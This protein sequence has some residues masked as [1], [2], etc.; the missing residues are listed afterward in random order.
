[1][2]NIN[3]SF[4]LLNK[5]SNK[6]IEVFTK[7]FI[8]NNFVD[9]VKNET[10]DV[11]NPSTEEKICK[12][13]LAGE[14]D[15]DQAVKF[16]EKAFL[17]AWS[18]MP[19]ADKARLFFALA[20]L[21][22]KSIED[23]AYLETLD[24]GKAYQDS[25][26]DIKEVVR[27]IR[28]NGGWVDKIEGIT[29]SPFDNLTIHSR[30]VPYGVV[31]LISPWNYPLLMCAWKMFPALAAGNTI[32]LKPSEET[33]LT[34]L[35]L[36]KLIKEAGFPEGVINIL[37]GFGHIAGQRISNHEKIHKLSFTGSTNTGRNILRSASES[38][39][40]A[41]HLELGGKS[42]II[43]CNDADLENA[44]F[45]S[46]DGAF[47]NT[48]QNCVCSSRFLVQEEIYSDFVTKF[49]EKAKGIKVGDGFNIENFMGPVINKRQFDSI[50]NFIKHGKEV[51]NLNLAFGGNRLYKKGYFIEPTV[52]VDVD[53]DSKLA[54]EEIFGPVV[55]ILKPFK[56][57]KEAIERANN[58][59]YGLAAGIFSESMSKTEYFVRNIQAGSIWVNTYNIN[60]YNIPFGGLKQSGYGRDNGLE[61]I[62]E[63]T[64]IK[65][66]YYNNR[67]DKIK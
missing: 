51:E 43:V 2:E 36:G 24:N 64:S 29:Y 54:K 20:D 7:L 59:R 49:V 17:G 23:F 12:I 8:N 30:R 60:P 3:E 67:L 35:K 28:Y 63:Y 11:F 48:S 26:E 66:V 9:S 16:A 25:V 1:M 55:C 44:V 6:K 33:P 10:L 62:L 45:Y 5:M 18:S 40:K 38:N 19:L 39:L 15:V 42:P 47:R 56:T 32:V 50:M 58:S 52:F 4:A 34:I 61:G 37:P 53:D 13:S 21:L 14:D 27:C 65:A 46:I 31:G 22:E 57:L 41:L